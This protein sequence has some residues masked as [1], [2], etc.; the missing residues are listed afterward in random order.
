MKRKP[1][2]LRWLLFAGPPVLLAIVA[3]AFFRFRSAHADPGATL[4]IIQRNLN[5]NEVHYDVQVGADGKLAREPVV[6]YWIMKAE[7]GRREDLTFLEGKLA[8]GF[9]VSDSGDEREMKLVAWEDRPIRLKKSGGR[10]RA[11][12]TIDG[13]DA[14]LTRLF[15]QSEEGGATPTV[16]WVDLFG[17]AVDGGKA[18]KEHVVR[19]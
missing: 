12:T 7:G 8:Y 11:V 15:I 17:E 1:R 13:K 6:A 18:V 9:E 3:L 10:W 4:F 2:I 5:S 14:Y 16:L 19:K